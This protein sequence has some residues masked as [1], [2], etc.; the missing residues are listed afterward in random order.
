MP[1]GGSAASRIPGSIIYN[2]IQVKFL[3]VSLERT[4]SL[5]SFALIKSTFSDTLEELCWESP[6]L[7]EKV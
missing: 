5:P 4:H 2:I 7:G 1:E 6:P 3:A